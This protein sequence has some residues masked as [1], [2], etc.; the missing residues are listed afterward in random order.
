MQSQST[1]H[2]SL[3]PYLIRESGREIVLAMD[4][5][6][7][8]ALLLLLRRQLLE[9]ASATPHARVRRP[10]P[11]WQRATRRRSTPHLWVRTQARFDP[12]PSRAHQ[13]RL[14]HDRRVSTL[15]R[16]YRPPLLALL[17]WKARTQQQELATATMAE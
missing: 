2:H 11:R 12:P 15:M 3:T 14:R 4:L 6:L 10:P 13:L 8:H 7:H 16:P 1:H 9:N 5:Y 17:E